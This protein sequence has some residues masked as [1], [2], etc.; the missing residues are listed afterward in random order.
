MRLLIGEVAT[1]MSPFDSVGG[2]VGMRDAVLAVIYSA[3]Y[4]KILPPENSGFQ[5]LPRRPVTVNFSCRRGL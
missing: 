4:D 3:A 1:R 2:F 5:A